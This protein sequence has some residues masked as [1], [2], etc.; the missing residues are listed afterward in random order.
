MQ[1]PQHLFSIHH[2]SEDEKTF[3]LSE[4]TEF[5]LAL[6]YAFDAEGIDLNC[7]NKAIDYFNKFPE[8]SRDESTSL[9]QDGLVTTTQ[10]MDMLRAYKLA[11]NIL[12]EIRALDISEISPQQIIDWWDSLHAEIAY[13]LLTLSP[14]DFMGTLPGQATQRQIFRFHDGSA[15]MFNLLNYHYHHKPLEYLGKY[16]PLIDLIDRNCFQN[17][18]IND[19]NLI[20]KNALDKQAFF[21]VNNLG[22]A[23]YVLGTLYHKNKLSPEDRDILNQ[24]IKICARPEEMESLRQTCAQEILDLWSTVDAQDLDSVAHFIGE[25]FYK[26]TDMHCYTNANGRL[27]TCFINIFL[28]SF[29]L[30]SILLRHPAER[31]DPNSSYSL[32]ITHIDHDRSYLYNHIKSRIEIAQT[33]P[34]DDALRMETITY[35]VKSSMLSFKMFDEFSVNPNEA[36]S[37]NAITESFSELERQQCLSTEESGLP[38]I[39]TMLDVAELLFNTLQNSIMDAIKL[40]INTGKAHYSNKKRSLAVERFREAE[41]MCLFLEGKETIPQDEL[42][43]Y[44]ANTYFYLG[45]AEKALSQ[46]SSGIF[47]QSKAVQ[48]FKNCLEYAAMGS[49][50]QKLAEQQLDKLESNSRAQDESVPSSIELNQEDSSHTYQ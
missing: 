30:P 35:R 49:K 9:L 12:L 45:F 37:I 6:V 8:A 20:P 41:N 43:T 2:Y 19:P 29:N 33:M 7:V 24:F 47:S 17:D 10:F 34:F 38:F 18:Q 11:Q 44:F 27:A 1:Q 39:K 22:K 50:T 16:Q 48:Y 32:A 46:S 36:V 42:S 21:H 40:K 14:D 26:I 23:L 5:N 15:E 25:V 3:D 28:R 31:D 4:I 13:G